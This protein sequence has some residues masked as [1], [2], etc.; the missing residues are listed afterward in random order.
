MHRVLNISS[1]LFFAS[2]GTPQGKPGYRAIF[3]RDAGTRAM[4]YSTS[5]PPARPLTKKNQCHPV[6]HPKVP[7]VPSDAHAAP[8]HEYRGTK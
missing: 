4:T 7:S 2:A 1:I 3:S 6:H 8:C 5:R